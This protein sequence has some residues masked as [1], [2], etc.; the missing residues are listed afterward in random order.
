MYLQTIVYRRDTERTISIKL[1][2]HKQS[3]LATGST[4]QALSTHKWVQ[5]LTQAPRQVGTGKEADRHCSPLRSLK[6]SLHFYQEG[7][8]VRQEVKP[9]Q[10]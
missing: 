8:T 3:F 10:S 4:E 6:A 9:D 7:M 5:S 1:G 2:K